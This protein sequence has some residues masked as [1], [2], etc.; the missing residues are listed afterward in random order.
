MSIDKI[1][2]KTRINIEKYTIQSMFGDLNRLQMTASVS[3]HSDSLA[4]H[5]IGPL[6][7]GRDVFYRCLL[8]EIHRLADPIV[9]VLLPCGLHVNM[10]ARRY[11][12]CF[13]KMRLDRKT[14]SYK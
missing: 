3:I 1:Q 9:N 10:R 12:M 8:W 11:F 13:S 5:S 7:N 4:S 14:A 2:D 6:V